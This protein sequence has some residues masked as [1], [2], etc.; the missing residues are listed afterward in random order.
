[1]KKASIF[2]A[3]SLVIPVY[4]EE[5]RIK[6]SLERI[7][8]YLD[9]KCDEYEIIIVDDGSTDRTLEV[10]NEVSNDRFRIIKSEKNRGKGFA[11]K[12]GM[13]TAKYEYVLFSD[14]DLS[15]P[16]E[17]IEKFE[18]YA[19]D[20][21]IIIGSRAIKGSNIEI[22]QSK[23]KE[24][25]GRVGN[26]LIQLVLLPGIQDTQ[27]GFKLFNKKS[28]AIFEKQTIDRWGFDFEILWLARKMG[29]KIKEVP[30]HWINDFGTKV[31]GFSHYVKTFR[32]L[33]K[34][35]WNSMLKKYNFKKND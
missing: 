17:E 31:S 2:K 8:Q 11:V 23:F 18:Q 5:K 10:I 26:R 24:F 35:K 21:D 15:T 7:V 30:V 4:N 16:I 13:L 29:F 14:A 22:H 34:I 19:A 32:E 9:K 27:C 28:T 12:K 20:F 6:K 33:L 1:M 3:F 25:L